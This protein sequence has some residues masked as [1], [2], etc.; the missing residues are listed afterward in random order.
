M[1]VTSR[2]RTLGIFIILMSVGTTAAAQQNDYDP[3]YDDKEAAGSLNYN[4]EEAAGSLNYSDA[5]A[6][7]GAETGAPAGGAVD[8]D[9]DLEAGGSIDMDADYPAAEPDTV[10]SDRAGLKPWQ[11]GGRRHLMSVEGP[12]GLFYT[13]EAGSDEGGTF[14]IGFHGGFFKYRDYLYYGDTHVNMS[15]TL[16]LRITPIKYLEIYTG[17][18]SQANYNDQGNPELFQTL[19]DFQL[20]LKGNYAPVPLVTLGLIFGAEFKNPVGEVDV[21]FKG[22]TLPLGFLT[23]FDFAELNEKVPLRAHL[24]FIYRFDNSAKLIE[25]IEK[26]RGGCGT[27]EDG[28]IDEDGKTQVDF[29]G[30][31]DPVERK[32]LDIDRTDQFWD[33]GERASA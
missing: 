10:A 19:G 30:C 21:S 28:V 32:G 2:T 22:V 1:E 5:E 15:G 23:T 16:N 3:E 26:A 11:W 20:G 9:T 24:N 27:D 6:A 13:L 17:F 31:L 7:G 18:E 14:G 29:D 12:T 33:A 4:D 25:D 8:A